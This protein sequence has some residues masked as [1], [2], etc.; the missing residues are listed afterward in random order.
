MQSTRVGVVGLN[1]RVE[2]VVLPGLAGSPR[3]TV[4]AVCSRDR[5]KAELLA[6]AYPG[7][8]PFDDY[9]AMLRDAELDAVFILTP[10]DRHA[11]M[12]LAA[13]EAGLAVCGEKP[14]A[15]TVGEA[16]QMVVAA[17]AKGVR[18]AVNFTYRSTTAHRLMARE[19]ERERV[20][21]PIR[22]ELA[23]RQSRALH[24]PAA[25]RETLLDLGSH[26]AECLL[27]WGELAQLGQA[28]GILAKAAGGEP[29]LSWDVLI[30]CGE[31]TSAAFHLAREEAGYRNAM[32][33]L[34]SGDGGALR[35]SFDTDHHWVGRSGPQ[36]DAEWREVA[37]PPE[38]V[39]GYAAFPR[40]HFDRL[41]GALRGEEAFPDFRAGLRVQEL[42]A[43]ASLSALEGRLVA[44]S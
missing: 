3:A 19:L 23:Y 30:D 25:R 17:M 40:F 6:A 16:R 18:T 32:T 29:P 37:T 34:V 11:D 41:V 1:A 31:G 28:R 7:C 15:A 44:L 21:R 26:I 2:R 5:A 4:A 20:G 27:W 36:P 13:I 39:L 38:L 9:G 8:R 33:A 43:A 12:A 42:L 35:L 24:D 14:L 10:P 22:F